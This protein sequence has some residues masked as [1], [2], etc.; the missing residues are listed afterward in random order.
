MGVLGGIGQWVGSIGEWVDGESQWVGGLGEWM[1][2][3]WLAGG[4]HRWV[5]GWMNE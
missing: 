2:F 4:G 5:G 1:G 3:G